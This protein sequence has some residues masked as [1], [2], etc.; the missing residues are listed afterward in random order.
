MYLYVPEVSSDKVWV[1]A[2]LKSDDRPVPHFKTE[3]V[4]YLS[5]IK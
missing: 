2:D 4:F 1:V 5:Q 3:S